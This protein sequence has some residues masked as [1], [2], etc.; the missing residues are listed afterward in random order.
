M[1]MVVKLAVT[2]VAVAC[3]HVAQA[4]QA[5]EGTTTTGVAGVW[6]GDERFANGVAASETW[7]C[8]GARELS[9][10][11]LNDG[12][13][14]CA[15]GS[16]EP[17]TSACSSRVADSAR[18][19]CAVTGSAPRPSWLSE[20]G[21]RYSAVGDG[22]CDCCDCS[23]EWQSTQ[24]L[25]PDAAAARERCVAAQ[26]AA[27][28]EVM[29]EAVANARGSIVLSRRLTSVQGGPVAVLAQLRQHSEQLLAGAAQIQQHLRGGG[30]GGM[31][32]EQTVALGRRAASMYHQS[33]FY[34]SFE[35]HDL[36]ADGQFLPL[37][38]SCFNFTANER[39]FR[40]GCARADPK[41][42]LFTVCPLE[43]VVQ[44]QFEDDDD[45]NSEG[46]DGERGGA[47]AGGGER[48]LGDAILLGEWQ[49]FWGDEFWSR[50]A[51]AGGGDGPLPDGKVLAYGRIVAGQATEEQEE[52]GEEEEKEEEEEV[53]DDEDDDDA[54]WLRAQA[55]KDDVWRVEKAK[56]LR[57]ERIQRRA[58]AD[59]LSARDGVHTSLFGGG[60]ECWGGDVRRVMLQMRCGEAD[61]VTRVQEDGTCNYKVW[62]QS[63]SACSADRVVTLLRRHR[64]LGGSGK[65]PDGATDNVVDVQGE[66]AKSSAR[67]RQEPTSHGGDIPAP[68]G[69][70]DF[71]LS[72]FPSLRAIV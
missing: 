47:A 52:G 14:D 3:L 34:G 28:D 35:L 57:A 70:W 42:F 66:Q 29:A 20:H 11:V 44:Y 56:V 6:P 12:F 16:D 62:M 30:G 25:L 39:T 37:L 19:A 64:A 65:L 17:G 38:G 61:A 68:T 49:G 53:D 72:F 9:A 8:D 60:D 27:Q 2:V 48:P 32:P 67:S 71:V 23:D 21:V 55:S 18:F 58:W 51:D 43:Q 54:A 22:V 46:G 63:P 59:E 36:G 69:L 45:A 13:C 26:Q 5:T 50:P 1:S 7:P 15:D 4:G 10:A 31:S 24:L 41:D 40:G 33:K